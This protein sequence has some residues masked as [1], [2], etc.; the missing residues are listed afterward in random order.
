MIVDEPPVRRV[1]YGIVGHG[2]RADFYLRLAEALP[3][4]F[5]VAGVVTRSADV[6]HALEARWRIPT[7]RTLGDVVE[8][9]PDF[10]VTSVPWVANP[11][12]IGELV[13]LG[14]PVLAETPPAP[15]LAGLIQLWRA[16]GEH[17]RVQVAEQHLFLPSIA[18]RLAVVGS[19]ALGEVSSVQ[20]SWTHGYH[21][22]C[23]VRGLLNVGFT[24]ATVRASAFT[25]PLV[26]GPDRSGW[27]TEE[28]HIDAETVMATID[29]GDGRFGLYDFTE[30]QWFS[31]IRTR[32]LVVR[33]ARGE[34]INDRVVHLLDVRTPAETVLTRQDTGVDG[35]LEGDFLRA[36][37]AWGRPIW[38]NPFAPAR[39]SD[40][41]I[42]IACCL[43][44]M[45]RYVDGGTPVYD[46]AEACQDHYL[47]L[48]IDQAVA[49]NE[50]VT[51]TAQP[52][53]ASA[54]R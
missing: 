4:R 13:G 48:L 19:G 5:N 38:Q 21:A 6:G 12:V 43:A 39:L 1:E 50:A 9:Q 17:G 41:E 49:T 26:A 14:V 2:W 31:P 47:S 51:S 34:I 44:G 30:G 11:V 35:D 54:H 27:P 46:L 37:L 42:A 29:F 15:D 10:V 25:A 20:V 32:R 18:A 23:I 36:V 33:G 45:Q 7:Y 8:R 24:D 16:V 40:E 53:A 28:R 3:E 22:M 52:W